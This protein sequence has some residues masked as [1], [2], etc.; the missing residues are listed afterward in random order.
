[1]PTQGYDIASFRHARG[2]VTEVRMIEVK[3]V[4][5]R[6]LTFF[7]TRNEYET[8]K[9]HPGEY[10]LYLV[11]MRNGRPEVAGLEKIRDPILSVIQNRQEWSIETQIYRC[12]REGT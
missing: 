1:M 9:G 3:A 7:L 5:Y 4:S 2:R 8:A 11:P 12:R 6:D 10:F